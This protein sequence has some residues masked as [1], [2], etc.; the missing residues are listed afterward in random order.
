MRLIKPDRIEVYSVTAHKFIGSTQIGLYLVMAEEVRFYRLMDI[1]DDA[2]ASAVRT[3]R[4]VCLLIIDVQ[5]FI[6]I[7][8]D[9]VDIDI[10]EAS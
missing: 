1:I 9:T 5:N 3:A 10:T 4:A 6:D 2:F 7:V 8:N